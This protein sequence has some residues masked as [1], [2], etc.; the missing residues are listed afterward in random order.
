MNDGDDYDGHC[1]FVLDI[2]G[3]LIVA[4]VRN[5]LLRTPDSIDSRQTADDY[6]SGRKKYL[7]CIGHVV[8]II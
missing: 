1:C 2:L 3:C 7:K 8:E 6:D 5:I 4:G